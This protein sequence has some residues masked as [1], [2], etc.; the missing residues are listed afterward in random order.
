M[1]R[2]GYLWFNDLTTGFSSL[3]DIK[4]GVIEAVISE[5]SSNE[6]TTSVLSCLSNKSFKIAANSP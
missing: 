4:I 6:T 1:K 5:T 3:S 2:L